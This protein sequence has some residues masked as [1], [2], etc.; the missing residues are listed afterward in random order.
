MGTTGWIVVIVIGVLLGWLIPTYAV[1]K[2]FPVGAWLGYV[3]GIVGA[4][5]GGAYLGTW[6]W[7]LDGANVI[8][9]ILI[10]AL[11]VWLVGFASQEQKST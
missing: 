5:V 6:G 9:A 4:W 3:L 8:G 2:R 7:M 10:S 11:L 1:S